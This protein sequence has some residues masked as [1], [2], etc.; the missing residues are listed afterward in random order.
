MTT[1]SYSAHFPTIPKGGDI[2][3][4]FENYW[5]KARQQALQKLSEDE[6]LQPEKL[7]QVIDDYLFTEKMP[8]RNTIIEMLHQRPSLG[9]RSSI[10]ARITT[11][12]KDFIETFMD[13]VD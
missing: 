13:G 7:Q 12:I 5:S 9:K 4:A 10:S 6:G 1:N 3:Q 8:L 2:E 11:K